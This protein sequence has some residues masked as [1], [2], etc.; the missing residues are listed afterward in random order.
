MLAL[1]IKYLFYLHIS[2]WFWFSLRC[3][4]RKPG[5][6]KHTEQVLSHWAASPDLPALLVRPSPLSFLMSLAALPF[7]SRHPSSSSYH[8]FSSTPFSCPYWLHI[9]SW[10]YNKNNNNKISHLINLWTAQVSFTWQLVEILIHYCN[11]PSSVTFCWLLQSD[12]HHVQKLTRAS[13]LNNL[14]SSQFPLFLTS[15]RPKVIKHLCLA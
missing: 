3:H 2:H 11:F 13:C 6:Q 4:R 1:I 9:W 10:F 7:I 15:F 14:R 12:T 8:S 5:H